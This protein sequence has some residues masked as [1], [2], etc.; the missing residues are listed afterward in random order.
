[1]VAKKEKDRDI[2]I[3]IIVNKKEF[4]WKSNTDIPNTIFYLQRLLY[5]IN[6]DMEKIDKEIVTNQKEKIME[7][8]AQE[9]GE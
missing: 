7:E 8:P 6:K 9:T 2:K 5:L 4:T 1:M 3:E